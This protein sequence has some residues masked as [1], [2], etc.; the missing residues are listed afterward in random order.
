MKVTTKEEVEHLYEQA[1]NEM[2]EDDFCAIWYFLTAW[3]SAPEH[4]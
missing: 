2:L 3:G 4:T 1:M